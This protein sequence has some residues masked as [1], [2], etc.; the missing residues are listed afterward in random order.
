MV[1]QL[2]RSMKNFSAYLLRES[3]QVIQLA[4]QG[5]LRLI[6]TDSSLQRFFYGENNH[7]FFAIQYFYH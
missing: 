5:I 2:F 4:I 6:N 1:A 3:L 7:L